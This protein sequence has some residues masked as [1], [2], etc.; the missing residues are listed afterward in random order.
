MVTQDEEAQA[1]EFLKRAEIRTMKKDLRALR[2]ADALGERDKI[3]KIKT[4]PLSKVPQATL[5][6]G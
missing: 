3:A 6:V 4:F 2:E 1:K 5:Q